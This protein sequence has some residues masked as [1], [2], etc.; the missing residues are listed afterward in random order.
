MTMLIDLT[1]AFV[2]SCAAVGTILFLMW[3]FHK[4]TS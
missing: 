4:L 1:R 3:L 2:A